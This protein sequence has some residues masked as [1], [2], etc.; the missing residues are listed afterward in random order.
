MLLV[1][2][3]QALKQ[4]NLINLTGLILD[5]LGAIVLFKYAPHIV[6]QLPDSTI[7]A[8]DSFGLDK[9]MRHQ[10]SRSETKNREDK[11]WAKRGLYLIIFGFTLQFVGNFISWTL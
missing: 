3:F 4:V 11:K 5:I 2:T 8:L 10:I 9:S 1:L 7:R 6:A